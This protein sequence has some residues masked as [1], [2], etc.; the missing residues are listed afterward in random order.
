MAN[1]SF[2]Q[3]LLKIKGEFHFILLF[4]GPLYLRCMES[5]FLN[6]PKQSK[7]RRK[8]GYRSEKGKR[9]SY[10]FQ[11]KPVLII[12]YPCY[13]RR[14]CL[15]F[16]LLLASNARCFFSLN[17]LSSGAQRKRRRS[18]ECTCYMGRGFYYAQKKKKKKNDGS[19]AFD[20]SVH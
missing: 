1:S 9:N 5:I 4:S 3:S 19:D 15:H 12:T 6:G 10:S 13:W 17:A 16:S 8:K 20:P 18:R 2:G 14:G 7:L 11:T